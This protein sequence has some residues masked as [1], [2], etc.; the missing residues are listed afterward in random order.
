MTELGVSKLNCICLNVV[1]VSN[2][3][4][5]RR[6]RIIAVLSDLCEKKHDAAVVMDN[7][8]VR[9][10]LLSIH[11]VSIQQLMD[12]NIVLLSLAFI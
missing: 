7:T 4:V 9:I 5:I 6:I 8:I 3:I 2:L 11:M 10:T 12:N 1:L